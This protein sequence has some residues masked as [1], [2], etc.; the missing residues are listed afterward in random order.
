VVAGVGTEDRCSARG[1]DEGGMGDGECSLHL[2]R[3]PAMLCI[4]LPAP[5][6]SWLRAENNQVLDTVAAGREVITVARGMGSGC[7]A[8]EG[9]C[10][11]APCARVDRGE[12]YMLE[13]HLVREE[14][15]KAAPAMG[16]DH[17][18]CC[19]RRRQ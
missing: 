3:A 16:N 5:D 11:Q 2:L 13:R 6:T 17:R 10:M 9:S 7:C 18:T 15:I 12:W 8:H 14:A 19:A 1:G 4:V